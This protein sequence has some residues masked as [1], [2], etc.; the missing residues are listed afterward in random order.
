MGDASLDLIATG[1]DGFGNS[2]LLTQDG[3]DLSTPTAYSAGQ[4]NMFALPVLNDFNGD[5][6]PDIIGIQKESSL[7]RPSVV[8]NNGSGGFD[9]NGTGRYGILSSVG[10]SL[11]IDSNGSPGMPMV[12]FPDLD[13]DG[14]VDFVGVAGDSS[15]EEW[16]A[17]LQGDG[18]GG[19]RPFGS[20]SN[21]VSN[22]YYDESNPDTVSTSHE[23][24]SG[25]FD[26]DGN[27][28]LA[29][30]LSGNQV[31]V[32]FGDG[33]FNFPTNVTVAVS[34]GTSTLFSGDVN[35]DG[36]DDILTDQGN[37]L[38]SNGDRTFQAEAVNGV[39]GIV[40][41]GEFTGDIYT[42]VVIVSGGN[43][44]VIPGSST[45]LDSGSPVTLGSPAFGFINGLNISDV[46]KDGLIDV[47]V[48]DGNNGI[49][50]YRN[51]GDGTFTS[52]SLLLSGAGGMA[53]G[54]FFASNPGWEVLYTDLGGDLYWTPATTVSA[55]LLEA[56][57]DGSDLSAVDL[58]LDGTSDLYFTQNGLSHIRYGNGSGL[59]SEE[60]TRVASGYL[61]PVFA[62]FNGDGRLDMVIAESGYYQIRA[63]LSSSD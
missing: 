3:D 37:W 50:T 41:P 4:W 38:E 47:I 21:Q 26:G 42:D 27:A 28:D 39:T 2:A 11:P 53:V 15:G 44:Q 14:V 40:K 46:D 29:V 10:D 45:G 61:D 25:D 22:H 52:T 31:K 24:I 60:E 17:I 36:A 16:I 19:F 9:L 59:E 12:V 32:F 63:N 30:L 33:D 23:P 5:T 51:N 1:N 18:I 13:G 20:G 58:D 57:F 8:L 56:S 48:L 35:G 54:E 55:T 49:T 7:Y 34:G 6:F 43:L 62:D